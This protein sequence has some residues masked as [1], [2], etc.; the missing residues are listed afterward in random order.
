MTQEAPVSATDH[1]PDRVAALAQVITRGDSDLAQLPTTFLESVR[2]LLAQP[3]AGAEAPAR[4]L[5]SAIGVLKSALGR[6]PASFYLKSEHSAAYAAGA[7][8]TL[9]LFCTAY[10]DSGRWIQIESQQ[11]SRRELIYSRLKELAQ[12]TLDPIGAREALVDAQLALIGARP[13]ELSRAFHRLVQEGLVM[14]CKAEDRRVKLFQQT[15]DSLAQPRVDRTAAR[16]GSGSW[17]EAHLDLEHSWPMSAPR[18]HRA[19][20]VRRQSGE[21]APNVEFRDEGL[22][23]VL[24]GRTK[25]SVDEWPALYLASDGTDL[26]VDVYVQD[27]TDCLAVEAS[28]RLS[29]DAHLIVPL[30]SGISRDDGRGF[31]GRVAVEGRDLTINQ[32]SML[33]VARGA[34]LS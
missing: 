13:D 3:R 2:W 1:V 21:P 30:K 6:R 22:F 20:L 7:T 28:F 18:L 33:A 12:S 29:E 11:G 14:E 15:A 27:P 25:R 31:T 8:L 16:H 23:S 32:I 24:T 9:E 5:L 26:I 19:T 10:R 4:A 34:S 17:A